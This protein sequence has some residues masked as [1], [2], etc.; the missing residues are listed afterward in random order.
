MHGLQSS[1]VNF[2]AVLF[3]DEHSKAVQ[4]LSDKTSPFKLSVASQQ[5]MRLL[6]LPILRYWFARAVATEGP[7]G[8]GTI[9]VGPL[10]IGGPNSVNVQPLDKRFLVDYE[11][12][13]QSV[14]IASAKGEKPP[15]PETTLQEPPSGDA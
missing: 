14:A 13:Y 7:N 9:T 1:E 4:L 15:Y 3:A 6:S 2:D 11:R 5:K 8:Q 10:M 12:Y